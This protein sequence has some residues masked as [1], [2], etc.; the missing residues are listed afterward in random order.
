MKSFIS[1]TLSASSLLLATSVVQARMGGNT[2]SS[3]SSS[4]SNSNMSSAVDFQT[5]DLDGQVHDLMWCGNNDE[6]VLMQTGGG[7]IYR[8]RDR[9]L[10]WKR[11]SKLL[12]K[13]TIGVA[14][15]DQEVSVFAQHSLQ[16]ESSLSHLGLILTFFP[17]LSR[18]AKF[19][20]WFRTQ[21]TINL[22]LLLVSFG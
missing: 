12:E 6:V 19:T 1:A 17:S 10:T 3:S 20:R 18:L 15:E 13:T 21:M 4:S 8:S 7:G 2:G 11:L 16:Q 9:G 22:S 14:D 5:F